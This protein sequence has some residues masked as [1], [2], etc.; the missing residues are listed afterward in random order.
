MSRGREIS[1]LQ[2]SQDND[3]TAEG[4][5]VLRSCWRRYLGFLLY[6]QTTVDWK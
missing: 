1:V 3:K 2:V 5:T 6:G 4:L